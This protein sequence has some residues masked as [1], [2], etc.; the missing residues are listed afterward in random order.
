MVDCAQ[1]D[2]SIVSPVC[3]NVTGNMVAVVVGFTMFI[4][5]TL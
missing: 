3:H 2:A 1:H 5:D 4:G